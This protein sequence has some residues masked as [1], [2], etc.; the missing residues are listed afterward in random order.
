MIFQITRSYIQIWSLGVLLWVMLFGENPFENV[1]AAEECNL[2]FPKNEALVS[3]V[4]EIPPQNG[5][6]LNQF[7]EEGNGF[8]GRS[9]FSKWLALKLL[10]KNLFS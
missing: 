7:E 9:N 5:Q 2:I 3:E 1:V 4:T 10:T 8:L 6:H